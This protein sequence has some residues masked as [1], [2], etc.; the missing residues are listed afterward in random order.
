MRTCPVCHTPYDDTATHGVC[1]SCTVRSLWDEAA[2]EPS[3]E[4]PL[5]GRYR[6]G[7]RIGEGGF[8]VVHAAEQVT[9]VQ[10]AVAVKRLKSGL[11]DRRTLARFEAERQALALLDHPAVARVLDGGIAEDGHP[12]LVME[13]VEGARPLDVWA[14]ES[15]ADLRRRVSLLAAAARGVEHAHA[16]GIIHRDLKPSNILVRTDPATG[17]PEVK[18]IDFGIARATEHILTEATLLTAAG[19]VLGTPDYLSPEQAQSGGR[20]VDVRTDVHALGAI[21]HQ[22]MSGRPPWDLAARGLSLA[23]ALDVIRHEPPPRLPGDRDLALIAARAMEKDRQRRYPGAGAFADDLERWLRGDPVTARAPSLLYLSGKW[24]RRH[25]TAAAALLAAVVALAGGT[26]TS[27]VQAVRARR[28]ERAAVAATAQSDFQRAADLHAEGRADEAVA[29]LCQG[30]RRQP[31]DAA[32]QALLLHLLTHTHFLQPLA[33]VP[34][35]AR[36]GTDY[37]LFL[38]PSGDAVTVVSEWSHVQT[39]DLPG[40]TPRHA[41]VAVGIECRGAGLVNGGSELALAL[42]PH[43]RGH[44]VRFLSLTDGRESRPPLAVPGGAALFAVSGDGRRLLAGP[45]GRATLHAVEADAVRPLGS[46]PVPGGGSGQAALSHDGSLAVATMRSGFGALVRTADGAILRRWDLGAPGMAA[47][48]APDGS[49]CVLGAGGGRHA[50]EGRLLAQP[51]AADGTPLGTAHPLATGGP[52]NGLHYHLGGAALLAVPQYESTAVLHHPGS[53]APLGRTPM[54]HRSGIDC[55]AVTANGSH[56]FTADREGSVRGWLWGRES[57]ELAP[58]RL[59][60][61]VVDLKITTGSAHL[62]TVDAGGSLTLFGLRHATAAAPVLQ[63]GARPLLVSPDNS[64]EVIACG[65]AAGRFHLWRPG[66]AR[67]WFT[68]A[69]D[70]KDGVMA[71]DHASGVLAAGS[72]SGRITVHRI[73]REG[74]AEPLADVPVNG[75]VWCLAVSRDGRVGFG[76][77][78]GHAG[79]LSGPHWQIE[80]PASLGRWITAAT[81]SA[82]GSTFAAGTFR[83][84]ALRVWRGESGPV[85]AGEVPVPIRAVALSANGHRLAALDESGRLHFRT[86]PNLLPTD[87]FLTHGA[88]VPRDRAFAAFLPDGRHL[89]TGGCRDQRA[90]FWDTAAAVGPLWSGPRKRYAHTALVISPDGRTA[91]GLNELDWFSPTSGRPLGRGRIEAGGEHAQCAALSGNGRLLAAGYPDGSIHLVPAPVLPEE[92]APTWLLDFA[93]HRA[94]VRIGSGGRPEAIPSAL[95]LAFRPSV[96]PEA[97][98]AAAATVRW[99]LADPDKRP[100]WPGAGIGTADVLDQLASQTVLEAQRTRLLHRPEDPSASL[101]L[102]RLLLRQSTLA[103]RRDAA[104][105]LARHALRQGSLPERVAALRLLAALPPTPPASPPES[106]DGS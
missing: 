88:P 100:A 103:G 97:S 1:P 33:A 44:V 23:E 18:L 34:L 38:A 50:P 6:L 74:A 36:G 19:E 62:V 26:V 86:G 82:D 85:A 51:L 93:E 87:G 28:A 31:D 67:P 43:P 17:A 40:L 20:D 58:L 104:A 25:R 30:L 77:S 60:A 98:G 90:L 83:P 63:L 59:A 4:P 12:F 65:D 56:V 95:R 75:R 64:G 54:G 101:A 53:G 49:S 2:D 11:N 73:R 41:P 42:G 81:W 94:G 16:R 72:N 78:T 55:A 21:L 79:I 3:G 89:L 46:L 14:A 57:P 22:L 29:F 13:L 52:V 91:A 37:R 47:A 96:P 105:S 48:I 5:A 45:D 61:N 32:A 27:T 99:L 70:A 106:A 92:P 66:E 24:V 7:R 68:L 80:R 9:P 76:T 15:G 71:F 35:D 39:F 8:G 102:A 69:T 10:R 84:G